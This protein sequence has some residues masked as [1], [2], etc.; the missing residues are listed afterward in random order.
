MVVPYVD[1]PLLSRREIEWA[2]LH[3]ARHRS[4]A[5]LDGVAPGDLD[6]G[7][8]Y[9]LAHELHRQVKQGCIRWSGA[10]VG[11]MPRPPKPAREHAIPTLHDGVLLRAL[12]H[13]LGVERW[14]TISEIFVGGRPGGSIRAVIGDVS[15]WLPTAGW[16][17]RWDIRQA[18][19]SARFDHA[20]DALLDGHADPRLGEL[21]EGWYRRQRGRFGGLAEGSP[22]SPIL[23]AAL[24]DA[25]LVPVLGTHARKTRIWV[26]DGITVLDSEHDAHELRAN[27]EGALDDIGLSLHPEKSGVHSY[28]ASTISSWEFLGLRWHH[29]QAVVDEATINA[30]LNDCRFIV[31]TGDNPDKQKRKI[32]RRLDPWLGHYIAALP[33]AS[34]E[35]LLRKV[36]AAIGYVYPISVGTAGSRGASSPR[37]G[38]GYLTATQAGHDHQGMKYRRKGRD[39]RQA[40]PPGHDHAPSGEES[41]PKERGLAVS[42]TYVDDLVGDLRR[43]ARTLVARLDTDP[44]CRGARFAAAAELAMSALDHLRMQAARLRSSPKVELV[45]ET[46]FLVL[47]GRPEEI[48]FIRQQ[49]RLLRKEVPWTHGGSL[50][51]L[52]CLAFAAQ[53][54]QMMIVPKCEACGNVVRPAN[55][56]PIRDSKTEE[57]RLRLKKM[58]L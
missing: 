18:F 31:D 1:A 4:A 11:R 36:T 46:D 32:Q 8:L 58:G 30:V 52:M 35:Q 49:V 33:P 5:G 43:M 6:R 25:K 15:S 55:P 57:L 29:D 42:A 48:G 16:I 51:Y 47:A 27:I 21:V 13:R 40:S 44:A 20:L 23:L 2:A 38:G 9:R 26:D 37:A 41:H 56:Y 19:Y 22:V 24:L 53:D 39:V 10:R 28:D 3:V 54:L 12:A 50:V 14:P 17:F 7:Q 45:Q 34:A